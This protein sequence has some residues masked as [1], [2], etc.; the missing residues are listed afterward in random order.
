MINIEDTFTPKVVPA[1]EDYPFGSIKPNSAQGADDGTRLAAVWGNDYEGFRQNPR[2]FA[3][4]SWLV[5][6]CHEP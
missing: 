4:D 2:Q 5:L 1:S 6:P 3:L